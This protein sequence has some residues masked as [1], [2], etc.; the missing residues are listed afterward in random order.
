MH[1]LEGRA[2]F[3]VRSMPDRP[4]IVQVGKDN[5][6]AVGTA[7]SVEKNASAVS[8]LLQEGKVHINEDHSSA[9]KPLVRLDAGQKWQSSN[10]EDQGV[11]SDIEDLNELLSWRT[12]TFVF[13]SKPLGLVIEE[14]NRYSDSKIIIEDVELLEKK[15]NAV[16]KVGRT[17]TFIKGLEQIMDVG[18][19]L[20]EFGNIVI[21]D[22]P[23]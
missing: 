11:V 2:Y 16:Y 20:D 1:L 17:G 21:Y 5:V 4:F 22:D 9:S 8:V 6:K 3:D 15:V 10:P 12:G 18:F 7:F 14:V 13:K 23:T 19:S